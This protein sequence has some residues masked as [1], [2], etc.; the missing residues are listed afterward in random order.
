MDRKGCGLDE[1]ILLLLFHISTK[2]QLAD[3]RFNVPW[4]ILGNLEIHLPLMTVGSS[5]SETV[6]QVQIMML[7]PPCF[8]TGLM[9]WCWQA[10]AFWHFSFFFFF[11]CNWWDLPPWCSVT[12]TLPVEWLAYGRLMNRNV[13]QFQW[14]LQA[15]SCSLIEDSDLCLWSYVGWAPTIR[16]NR[17]CCLYTICLTVD[18]WM[19][20]HL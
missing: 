10:V 2:L 8:T 7:P 17:Q 5:C 1:I 12:D 13:C 14:C 9:I 6:K 19:P 18:W 4:H 3:S 11:F 20:K 15:F 16:K